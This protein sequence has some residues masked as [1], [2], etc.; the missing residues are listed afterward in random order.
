[1]QLGRDVS[2]SVDGRILVDVLSGAVWVKGQPALDHE[3]GPTLGYQL[4]VYDQQGT[5]TA[6]LSAT[7]TLTITVTDVNERPDN[8]I[9]QSESLFSERFAGE[10]TQSGGSIA[11]FHLADPDGAAYVPSLVITGG[12]GNGWFTVVG[13]ELRFATV[14]FSAEWFRTTAGAY[15]QDGMFSRDTDGDGLLEIRVATVTLEARDAAGLRS[16]PISYDVLIED[17][18][19]APVFSASSYTFT[20]AENRPQW[21]QIGAVSVTDDGPWTELRHV[22]SGGVYAYEAAV[23]RHM[24]TSHDGRFAIDL[25]DGTVW[26]KAPNALDHEGFPVLNYEVIV[27]DR[28]GVGPHSRSSTVSLTINAANVNEHPGQPVL[29]SQ[30]LFSETFAGEASHAGGSIARFLLH[31]PDGAAYV[32]SLV[33]AAGNDHG[34]FTV[35]GNELKFANANF[36]AEWFRTTMGAYGQDGSFSR[37][38]DGDGLKEIRVATLT[39]AA[40]D[41]GGLQSGAIA[42]EVLIEDRLQAP[43]FGASS[44][45]L[46]PLENRP[47][48]TYLGQVLAQ[49]DGPASELRHVFVNGS[50]AY[51][52]AVGRWMSTTSDGRF[53]IDL[54]DGT[55]WTKAANALNHEGFPSLNYQVEVRDRNGEG[56]QTLSATVAL[57]INAQN[58]NET[59][60]APAVA[61]QTLHSET[62]AGETPHSGQVIASFHLADPDGAAY[63]PSL[64]ITGGNGQGWFTVSGNQLKFAPGV[65][66]SADWFRSTMGAYGQDHAFNYDTD[67]D[68]LKEIRVATLTLAARDSGGLQSGA[69]TYDVL[70]EDRLQ[71]PVFSASSY[72]FTPQENRPQWTYL[73]QVLAQDDGPANELRHL[74]ANGSVAYEGAVGRWMSTSADGRFAI[75]LFDGTVWTKSAAALDYETAPSLTYQVIVRDKHGDGAQMRSSTVAVT[76]NA[77]DVNEGLPPIV[78]DLA[79]QGLDKAFGPAVVS[80]DFDGTGPVE[81]VHWLNAGFGFLAL[82][83]NGDGRINNGLEISFTQDKPG[84]RTDLEGLAAYDGNGDGKL[85]AADLKFGAFLVWQDANSDG[86]SQA[87][88]LKTLT[89]AGIASISLTPNPTGA[90]LEGTDGNVILNTAGF[91]RADGTSGIIGDV[92]L[93][94]TGAEAVAAATPAFQDRSF[95]RSSKR[96]AL[97][98]DGGMLSI[99]P[100]KARGTLDP[101]AG[102]VGP[103]TILTFRNRTLGMLAPVVLDLDGDGVELKSIG[104]A[105]A[106]IDMNGDGIADDT[107]WVGRNDG[108]LVI[109]RD[110]DGRIS[111]P[112][113]LSFLGD[114]P[115]AKGD[116]DALSALDS[117][118]DGKIDAAD[119]RFG[120]LRIWVDRDGDGITDA[121]ELGTLADHNIASIGLASAAGRAEG[122]VGDNM[123]LSTGTFTPDGRLDGDTGRCRS[124]LPPGADRRSGCVHRGG[125]A[126]ARGPSLRHGQPAARRRRSVRGGAAAG[127]LSRSSEQ[128]RPRAR[129]PGRHRRLAPG[130]AHHA[131][132]PAYGCV[133]PAA[134]RG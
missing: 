107:G 120:E 48:W 77:Q 15:G 84:A 62:F 103:A 122:R 45:L 1:V 123:V 11:R 18:L 24:S 42:F 47:Q 125:R 58:V 92:V 88:E 76:I 124:R 34:W 32:P 132:D 65:S 13:N 8:P 52:A 112:A 31:D 85:T 97:V 93:R 99:I 67:G 55:V 116:L 16:Q 60:D 19:Q 106:R 35:S 101:R 33:I 38:T 29:Q 81:R 20:P 86:I 90:T 117:N 91:T 6:A 89:Q 98:A 115:G 119:K 30:T 105:K 114:K 64:V 26:T 102:E 3:S 100:V 72:V 83:R 28:G 80:F 70:I 121:G 110:N 4:A 23:G 7:A 50:L 41:A 113:E 104:K 73:G 109:D 9:V 63:V 53:A 49:D 25:F 61:S 128:R 14:D 12:N 69:I 44:F 51:E 96:Y 40:R 59:P 75:D 27:R 82:D 39:L 5:G 68:G 133:R 95:D 127:G 57:T 2:A 71:A 21:T 108:M 129:G 130:C 79:S 66:F 134:R 111:G 36:S 46:T 78:F 54:F 118:R 22:F 94:Q 131:D 87:S 43:V 56:A 17:R 37:D 126:A 10:P 74:F